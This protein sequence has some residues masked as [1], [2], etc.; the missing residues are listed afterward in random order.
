M[1]IGELAIDTAIREVVI[2]VNSDIDWLDTDG[3][4]H[5]W[6]FEVMSACG[7]YFVDKEELEAFESY[8]EKS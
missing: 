7:K 3:Q 6:D 8:E 4:N 1:K 2:V 5:H